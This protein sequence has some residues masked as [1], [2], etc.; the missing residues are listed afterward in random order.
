MKHKLTDNLILK[1]LSVLMAILIW[2]VV[3]NINDPSKTRIVSGIKVIVQNDSVILDNNQVYTI[4][5]GQLISVKVTGPRT[6]V[7]SLKA[8]D[9][10]AT[11]D[12]KDLSQANSVPINV[13]LNEY[14]KQQK[15]TINEKSNN[16]LRLDI[17]DLTEQEYDI[18]VK[19]AG[20][21]ETGYI[22][23]ETKLDKETVKITA[24]E[25]VHKNIKEVCA[26][27]NVNEV[28]GDF[29]QV[30]PLKV[31]DNKGVELIR[32]D[33]HVTTEITQVNTKN[34]VYYTK[35]VEISHADIQGTTPN[36]KISSTKLSVSYIDV[37]G[38]K[39]VLDQFE[40]LILPT[41]GIVIDGET[42]E[43]E[44]EYKVEDLL[45]AG[46]YLN[47]TIKHVS[48]TITLEEIIQKTITIQVTDIGIKN[49][50]DGM[51]ASI[52]SNGAV[53]MVLEGKADVLEN[54]DMSN[55]SAYVSLK[56][57]REGIH[58]VS[59]QIQSIDDVKMLN[60]PNVEVTLTQKGESTEQITT[61][62]ID[63]DTT[64]AQ[65]TTTTLQPIETTQTQKEETTEDKTGETES[66]DTVAE[67]TTIP[68]E[69]E[70]TKEE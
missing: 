66:T 57:L 67:T 28:S 47:D 20:T 26:T 54:I 6:I 4:T 29:E 56:N 24:P 58:D 11:A 15:V 40:R 13:S 10:E 27:V 32:A 31:Y 17:E 25:S 21:A 62:P 5:E 60:Q 52:L 38:R 44:Q 30:V 45:P 42:K 55:I 51:D 12:F 39:E 53:S 18:Q 65:E 48:L 3:L 61:L 14:A 68:N 37:M 70:T 69:S 8:D 64:R 1:I 16:T 36:I 50:P 33:N 63:P 59:V 23:A 9:F 19:Y 49:I 22:L 46:I 7:D 41:E 43:I 34:T 2:I 35:S